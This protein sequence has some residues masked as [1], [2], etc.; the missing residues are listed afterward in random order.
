MSEPHFLADVHLGRLTSYLRLAGFDT[1]YEAPWD[2]AILAR[3]SADEG[4]ILLTRDRGLLERSIVTRG[5]FVQNTH[6]REQFVELVNRFALR[7]L[8]RPFTR[9][10]R[11]NAR[12]RPV[13][14]T[15]V[16]DRLQPRT[17]LTHD[18]FL[19]CPSCRRVYWRGSHH[20]KIASWFERL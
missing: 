18:E 6:P 17:R 10:A 19:E 7:A 11:C 1:A 4:R 3:R 13:P 8:M 14:K 15:A 9:C 20:A 5:Y 16:L 12:L 2:D